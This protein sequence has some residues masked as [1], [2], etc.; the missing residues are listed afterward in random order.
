MYNC[1][2][3]QGLQTDAVYNFPMKGDSPMRMADSRSLLASLTGLVS[4]PLPSMC[5][6]RCE[7]AA[8]DGRDGGGGMG[9]GTGGSG[10][11][12]PTGKTP[13][14]GVGGR[15][16]PKAVFADGMG[17]PETGIGAIELFDSRGSER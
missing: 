10:H 8:G 11:P 17:R 2:S 1:T 13:L 14:W 9:G 16:K 7:G 12:G 6:G 5:P 3:L 15:G 4:T